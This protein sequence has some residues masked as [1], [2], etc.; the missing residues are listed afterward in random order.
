MHAT[1]I[2]VHI[3]IKTCKSER[4][5][6]PSNKQ[7]TVTITH[8]MTNISRSI[9]PQ[10]RAPKRDDSPTNKKKQNSILL[11]AAFPSDIDADLRLTIFIA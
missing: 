2:S 4:F 11:K 3:G 9:L 6:S 1:V 5:S 7:T 10:T 8:T